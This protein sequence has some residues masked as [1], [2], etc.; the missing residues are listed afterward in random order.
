M[1]TVKFEIEKLNK[2]LIFIPTAVIDYSDKAENSTIY[3]VFGWLQILFDI[4][5]QWRTR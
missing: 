2:R 4:S 1:V 3:L 5:I